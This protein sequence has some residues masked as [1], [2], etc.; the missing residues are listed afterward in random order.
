MNFLIIYKHYLENVMHLNYVCKI[1]SENKNYL[2]KNG[3]VKKVKSVNW[4]PFLWFPTWIPEL[5]ASN[6]IML[7]NC[8]Q[9]H[10]LQREWSILYGALLSYVVKFVSNRPAKH[11]QRLYLPETNNI[12]SFLVHQF[13]SQKVLA[14]FFWDFFR[15]NFK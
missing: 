8:S 10:R 7:S 14:S 11:F 1:P 5:T 6:L 12:Y 2:I 9:N 13:C 4:R 3:Q 15:F